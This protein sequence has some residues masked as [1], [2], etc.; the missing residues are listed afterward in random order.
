MREPRDVTH[1]IQYEDLAFSIVRIAYKLLGGDRMS[2][3]YGTDVEIQWF[4]NS[5]IVPYKRPSG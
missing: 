2:M 3:N 4:R 5:Y 1:Q